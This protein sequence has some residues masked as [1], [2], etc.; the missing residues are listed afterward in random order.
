MNPLRTVFLW[1]RRADP[2]G[3]PPW[4]LPSARD[5]GIEGKQ[6]PPRNPRVLFRA[7]SGHAYSS[8]PDRRF[9]LRTRNARPMS[10]STDQSSGFICLT[11][12]AGALDASV[13]N[14]CLSRRCCAPECQAL[15]CHDL[16][17]STGHGAELTTSKAVVCGTC[18]A[19]LVR[20]FAPITMR[21]ARVSCLTRRISS[22][23]L[24]TTTL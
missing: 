13:L 22:T 4:P 20:F 21:P 18:P 12:M 11:V 16:T 9:F 2:S 8:L 5:M 19:R 24:P 17:V 15:L 1:S 10:R 3:S 23:G 7:P 14:A 6:S